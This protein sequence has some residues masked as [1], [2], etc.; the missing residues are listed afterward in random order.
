MLSDVCYHCEHGWPQSVITPPD[1]DTSFT[2]P[3]VAQAAQSRLLRHMPRSIY[4]GTI[5]VSRTGI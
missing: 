4:P 5:V 3:P 2:V 1:G